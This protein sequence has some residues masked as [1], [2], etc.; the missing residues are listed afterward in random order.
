MV[1]WPVCSTRPPSSTSRWPTRDRLWPVRTQQRLSRDGASPGMR[2]AASAFMRYSVKTPA[3]HVQASCVG[4]RAQA[5]K[6]HWRQRSGTPG[7]YEQPLLLRR[8]VC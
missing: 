6:E 4:A 3:C 5:E 8:M 7:A 1:F 2:C